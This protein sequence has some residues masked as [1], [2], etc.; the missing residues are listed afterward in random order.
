MVKT[1]REGSGPGVLP[2]VPPWTAA[3]VRSREG[4]V[5]GRAATIG[6]VLTEQVPAFLLA[7]RHSV[8]A[9]DGVWAIPG[10]LKPADIRRQRGPERGRARP[11]EIGVLGRGT[12]RGPVRAA[13]LIRPATGGRVTGP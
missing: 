8:Y 5:P 13:A 12:W 6:A 11:P 1:R 3:G 2:P 7:T 9:A 10:A 4:V